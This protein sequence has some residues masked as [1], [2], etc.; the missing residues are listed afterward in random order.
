MKAAIHPYKKDDL[1]RADAFRAPLAAAF[2]LHVEEI[3]DFS[4]NER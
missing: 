4:E 3:A 1:I 2:K